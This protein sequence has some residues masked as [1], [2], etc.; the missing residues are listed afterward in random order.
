MNQADP[1]NSDP[2]RVAAL[3]EN[4]GSESRKQKLAGSRVIGIVRDK[5]LGTRPS[6]TNGSLIGKAIFALQSRQSLR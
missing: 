2:Y 3:S 6:D 1:P 5:M 4:F